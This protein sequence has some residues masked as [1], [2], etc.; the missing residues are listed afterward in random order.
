MRAAARRF[1]RCAPSPR[2][3]SPDPCHSHVGRSLILFVP[4][5]CPT[6][7]TNK[8]PA[9]ICNLYQTKSHAKMCS[10][11]IAVGQARLPKATSGWRHGAGY[12]LCC[13]GCRWQRPLACPAPLSLR[14]VPAARAG[15]RSRRARARLQVLPLQPASARV[16]SACVCGCIDIW[17]HAYAYPSPCVHACISACV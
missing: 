10:N 4:Q 2:F 1:R 7:S 17:T 12:S 16:P 11:F 6:R 8:R 5:A 15:T 14:R 13:W 3:P 9:L